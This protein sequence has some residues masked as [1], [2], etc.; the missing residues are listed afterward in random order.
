[1]LRRLRAFAAALCWPTSCMSML[2]GADPTRAPVRAASPRKRQAATRRPQRTSAL[3]ACGG[4]WGCRARWSPTAARPSMW[5]CPARR[6]SSWGL[7]SSASGWKARP[8]A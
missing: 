7:S 2:T 4:T 6:C 5:G 1:M 8:R 3:T